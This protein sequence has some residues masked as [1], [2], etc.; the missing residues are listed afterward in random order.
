MTNKP[1][2]CDL[3]YERGDAAALKR[4]F[5][6]FFATA[7]SATTADEV[8]RARDDLM[9]EYARFS[10]FSSLAY[11]RYTL[12]TE[13]E[14][15]V[16]EQQ[17]YDET[18]PEIDALY[19]EY[20]R[21]MLTSP[22]ADEMRARLVV[23]CIIFKCKAR[24]EMRRVV[25]IAGRFDGAELERALCAADNETAMFHAVDFRDGNTDGRRGDG[26]F[27]NGQTIVD[28]TV[29]TRLPHERRDVARPA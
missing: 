6:D 15:Y 7:K 13:D 29:V 4:A 19:T 21:A 17:Y 26:I 25:L 10:T 5:K 1:K 16:A 22:F 3:H 12:D 27:E 11:T 28:E 8:L 23:F 9:S 14:F 20:S 2:V 24:R 18:Q